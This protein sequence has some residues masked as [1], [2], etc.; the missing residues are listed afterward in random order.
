MNDRPLTGKKIV[1]TRPAKQ[2][3]AL[4]A[5]LAKEGAEPISFPVMHIEGADIAS[6]AREVLLKLEQFEWIAFTSVNGVSYFFQWLEDQGK[7]LSSQK[8]AAVGPKTARKLEEK[9]ISI[10]LMPAKYEGRELAAELQSAVTPGSNVLVPKGDLAKPTI[11]R[12]LEGLAEVTEL[13]VYET[14]QTSNL[15]SE[16]LPDRADAVIFMSPSSVAFF[17]DSAGAE[18][19]E[20]QQSVL[21]ACV[22]PVTAAKAKQLGFHKLISASDYTEEGI[23]EAVKSYFREETAT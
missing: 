9:G 14:R 2:S 8:I 19:K 4:L 20:Y 13:I 6:D 22:G 18:F 15:S 16:R 12:T 3:A 21:A 1:V 10:D 23:I 7:Q 5:T 11:L 17:K